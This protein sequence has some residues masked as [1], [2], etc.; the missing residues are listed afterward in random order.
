M[1]IWDKLLNCLYYFYMSL[2]AHPH[3]RAHAHREDMVL[4]KK[5]LKYKQVL[6]RLSN[7]QSNFN[8]SNVLRAIE[9]CSRNAWL[10]HWGLIITQ[11][12]TKQMGII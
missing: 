3:T 7:I 9:I 2:H 12:V 4:Y 8:G 11:Q 1:N 6:L 10:S 5:Q